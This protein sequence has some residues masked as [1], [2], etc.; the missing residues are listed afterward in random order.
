VIIKNDPWAEAARADD[1]PKSQ[2]KPEKAPFTLLSCKKT[3]AARALPRKKIHLV[4][5]STVTLLYV[6][7]IALY[8]A[9]IL[10]VPESLN[11]TD[12]LALAAELFIVFSI[13]RTV[14]KTRN[15]PVHYGKAYTLNLFSTVAFRA[16]F[17]SLLVV[18][19]AEGISSYLD[20]SD[21]HFWLY[22][23]VLLLS[24]VVGLYLFWRGARY[25]GKES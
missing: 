25:F 20:R 10:Y 8:L 19:A 15:S 23:D 4:I 16:F 7:L 21:R 9:V 2:K 24:S 18:L 3:F 13:C 5:Y 12:L 17:W 6:A 1:M 22:D 14:F 11:R